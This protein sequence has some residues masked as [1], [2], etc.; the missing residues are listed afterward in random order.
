MPNVACLIALLVFSSLAAADGIGL[1]RPLPQL[2]IEDR[3]ELLLEGDEVTFR[4]WVLPRGIGKIHVLQYMAAT[5]GASKLNEPFTDRLGEIAVP[6][7]VMVGEMEMPGFKA[8]AEEAAGGV[9][10]STLEV[11]PDC[12]THLMKAAFHDASGEPEKALRELDRAAAIARTERE[13]H[14]VSRFR[15]NLSPE[16]DK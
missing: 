15:H 5:R 12:G 7:A 14:E 4:P 11:V 1:G 10:G 13:R 8:F 16:K 6:T 3:G 2:S 9:P